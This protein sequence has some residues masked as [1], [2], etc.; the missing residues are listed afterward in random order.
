[1]HA[2]ACREMSMQIGIFAKTF[3][4]P[5]LAATLDA[6]VEHGIG[7]VQFNFHARARRHASFWFLVY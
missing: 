5:T 4:R 2:A 6:V 1:M 3:V 7:C